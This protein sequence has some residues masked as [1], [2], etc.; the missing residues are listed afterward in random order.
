M[1]V[2][3]ICHGVSLEQIKVVN[4][5]RPMGMLYNVPK[6]QKK[7]IFK[8]SVDVSRR[9]SKIKTGIK[10]GDFFET[11]CLSA[12]LCRHQL[13]L[14]PHAGRRIAQSAASRDLHPRRYLG[15]QRRLPF[16]HF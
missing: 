11:R 14:S 8:K 3:T 5:L 9:Y 10:R 1:E 16:P 12:F 4:W 13:S 6:I 2:K 7:N 15:N